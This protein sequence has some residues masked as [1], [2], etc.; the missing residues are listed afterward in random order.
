MLGIGGDPGCGS[1]SDTSELGTTQCDDGID[2]DGDGRIDFRV[3]DKASVGD[4]QCSGPRDNDEIATEVTTTTTTTTTTTPARGLSAPVCA[5]IRTVEG[6]VS[7]RFGP[8]LAAAEV[9][10]RAVRAVIERS[11][12]GR[13]LLSVVLRLVDAVLA[14]ITENPSFDQILR[15]IQRLLAS[16][17][18]P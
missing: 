8:F 2:N 12:L 7:T 14:E 17:A 3:G 4:D 18:Q 9:L 16:C 11:P 1:P 5:V 15:F 6:L 13:A 10:L